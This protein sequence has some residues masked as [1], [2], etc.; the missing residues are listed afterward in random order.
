MNGRLV[1]MV[2]DDR[3]E[4]EFKD[5]PPIQIPADVEARLD[6]ILADIVTNANNSSIDTA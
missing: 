1:F 4:A 3:V 2:C 5:A 6:A